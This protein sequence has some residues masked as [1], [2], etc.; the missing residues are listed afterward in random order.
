VSLKSCAS[1]TAK[2]WPSGSGAV[3]G[4]LCRRARPFLG[5]IIRVS[6][7]SLQHRQPPHRGAGGGWIGT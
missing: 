3:C 6:L 5:P 1:S 2:T 7:D 4:V